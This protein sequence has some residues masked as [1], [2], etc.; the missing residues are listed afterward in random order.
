MDYAA[1]YRAAVE[2]ESQSREAVYLDL[3]EKVGGYSVRPLTVLDY[4]TL[5]LVRSPFICGGHPEPGDVWQFLWHQSVK[6]SRTSKLR[7][8]RFRWSLYWYPDYPSLI[9]GIRAYVAEAL[10]DMPGGGK[11]GKSY[12][13]FL[14]SVVDCL[15]SEYGWTR[16]AI[17][18]LPIKEVAQYLKAIKRRKD[19]K[20]I[21]FNESDALFLK[22]ARAQ[23]E[24]A[25]G[26]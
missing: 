25:R 19:H 11:A 9:V 23:M 20:A 21:L 10:G 2:R 14:A 17:R 5:H 12:Y 13:S 15:A 1:E 7:A 6:Y 8:R 3:P 24:E 26:N 4:T 16:D 22:A 18:S